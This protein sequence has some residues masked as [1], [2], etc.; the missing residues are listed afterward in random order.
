MALIN[1]NKDDFPIGGL[2][3]KIVK[4]IIPQRNVDLNSDLVHSPPSQTFTGLIKSIFK[5]KDIKWLLTSGIFCEAIYAAI[6]VS[7]PLILGRFINVFFENDAVNK[8]DITKLSLIAMGLLAINAFVNYIAVRQADRSRAIGEAHARRQLTWWALGHSTGWFSS[9]EAGQVS[10]RISE[11]SRQ[12]NVV[13]GYFCWN[14]SPIVV[15]LLVVSFAMYSIDIYAG[16]FFS[17]WT[18]IFLF[19]SF[20]LGM[21]SQKFM[22]R[23]VKRRAEASGMV[24]DAIINNALVRLFDTKKLED[25]KVDEY[26]QQCFEAFMDASTWARVKNLIRDVWVV[27]L[28]S[29]MIWI[30]GNA[31][32][33]DRISVAAFVS[34]TGMLFVLTAQIKSLHH[35]IKDMLEAIG[36]IREGL[37]EIGTP[38]DINEKQS[39]NVNS[40]KLKTKNIEL[41]HVNFNYQ[42]SKTIL[43]DVQLTIPEG[44]KLGIV[45][46][47]G[48]GKTTLMALLLR[49]WDVEEGEIKIGGN[50]IKDIPSDVMR[51]N[52]A[53]IPQDTSLF[54]RSLMDNIRYGRLDAS[55]KD[56]IEA[57][58]KAYAHDFISEL[59]E[60]YE[61]L[62]GE[63][64]VKLSGGQRQRIAIARAV[65]KDP[66]ILILDEATSALDSESEQLIQ[67][68]Y[69]SRWNA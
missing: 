12:I 44:Q 41:N 25:Q 61:T 49:L 60:G 34:G 67:R 20:K 21:I 55:D 22:M 63:R 43:Q 2:F 19:M 3:E 36:A 38:H 30:L 54:H 29:S 4:A 27:V 64:G 6:Y 65:L 48:A 46:P 57:S 52:M 47:S 28:V 18:I 1:K 66:A 14:I 51:Q 33:N 13:L 24:T 31:L 32:I 16:L 37:I 40:E 9:R 42:S 59:P 10:Y 50:N 15:A 35:V 62:V 39:K 69:C 5:E 26:S 8:E 58:K 23:T 11:V 53:L 17:F 45:G 7:M 68:A 56:V